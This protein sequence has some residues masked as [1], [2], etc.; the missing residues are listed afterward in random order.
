MVDGARVEMFFAAPL[1][2]ACWRN[3]AKK[4]YST[5][6]SHPQ[7]EILYNTVHYTKFNKKSNYKIALTFFVSPPPRLNSILAIVLYLPKTSR[8]KSIEGE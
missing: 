5:L 6:S 8:V 2:P 1:Q 7:I 4:I 3:R